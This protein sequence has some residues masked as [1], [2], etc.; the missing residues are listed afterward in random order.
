MKK[1]FQCFLYLYKWN[2]GGAL[3]AKRHRVPPRREHRRTVLRGDGLAGGDP[4]RRMR[5]LPL[6]ASHLI[7][8]Q[9]R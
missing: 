2:A 1:Y 5:L 6:Y 9:S 4:G 8:D 7:S 3:C